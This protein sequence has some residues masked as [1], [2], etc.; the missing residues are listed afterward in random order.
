MCSLVGNK[1]WIEKKGRVYIASCAREEGVKSDQPYGQQGRN[2]G[3]TGALV[4]LM[5]SHQ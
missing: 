2:G 1:Q 4:T 3:Q 5:G